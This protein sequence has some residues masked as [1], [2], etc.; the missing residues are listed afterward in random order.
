MSNLQI[1]QNAYSSFFIK[2][3]VGNV[4]LF[5]RKVIYCDKDEINEN[6][7]LDVLDHARPI[8]EENARQIDYLYNYYKGKQPI[9]NRQKDVR[10][11]ICN[12]IVV[13]R[14]NEIVSFKVGYL[15]GEPIQYVSRASDGEVSNK[16]AQLNGL[17][18]SESKASK[19][20]ELI[21][22][23]MISGTGYRMVLP[24]EQED[25]D[26]APFE[27]YTLDPR[28]AFVIYSNKVGNKPLACVYY[29]KN[30]EQTVISSVYTHKK[31]FEIRDKAIVRNED[32]S[33]KYLPIIEYPANKARLGAFEI[34]IPILDA[35]NTV[36]ANRLDG[37]EQFIQ[38]LAIGVNCN[39]PEGTT[40]NEIRQAGMLLLKSVGENKA[41]FKILSEQLDQSQSQTLVDNLY[42]A[43][44]TITGMPNRNGGSSTSDTGSAVV[45]RDGWSAAETRAK[46][47][48][49][50]FK[51]SEQ[52]TLKL[53]L[54]ICRNLT[55]IDIKLSDIA[56]KFTRRNFENIET[57]A[58]V[59]VSMLNN[60]KIAPRLAFVHCG[61]FS[62]AEAAYKESQDYINSQSD[63]NNNDNANN[64][65]QVSSKI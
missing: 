28:N 62:D 18:L 35:I 17:M 26:E 7:V 43:V 13:N 15:C 49:L 4:E 9:L 21:E 52:E 47:S 14:A 54:C 1:L 11:E 64:N 51:E 24:D 45:Y 37:I 3:G 6:N 38:S 44:L 41:E 10:P 27:I 29:T 2:R 5:G 53:V 20:K 40:A 36:E 32:Y 58:S 16:V 48:E 8:H 60:D 65:A 61:M 50:M 39:F 46:D 42:Q 63:S 30:S 34:V 59:L 57:K 55:D 19:D 22:W 23:Q 25:A 33:L 56:I 12:K 31:F